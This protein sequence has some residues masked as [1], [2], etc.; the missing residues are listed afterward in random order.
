MLLGC[1]T[2]TGLVDIEAAFASAAPER[3]PTQPA[4]Q[5]PATAAMLPVSGTLRLAVFNNTATAGAPSSATDNSGLSFDL[6]AAQ[7]T[8]AELTGTLSAQPADRLQVACDFG[9]ATFATLHIDDHLVCQLGANA[10]DHC[11]ANGAWHS[12]NGTDSPLPVMSRTDLP[13]RLT[14]MVATAQPAPVKV[15][16]ELRS[17]SPLVL[18]PQLP[19]LEVRRRTLQGSLLQGWGMFYAMS[20]AWLRAE[21]F[22]T[23]HHRPS[24]PST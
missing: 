19:P 13:V 12:C 17:A 2:I 15:R 11:G 9:A 6:P 16:V 14:V 8:S 7:P 1:A 3:S 21:P 24:R 10:G 22:D 5:R 4:P 23:M 18:S 20:C